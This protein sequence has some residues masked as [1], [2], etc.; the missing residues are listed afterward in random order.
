MKKI[1]VIF[2]SYLTASSVF[3]TNCPEFYLHG[4]EPALSVHLQHEQPLTQELCHSSFATVYSD[5]MRIAFY[6]AEHLTAASVA[7]AKKLR[8]DNLFHEDP[9]LPDVV[10]A[11]LADYKDSG[12]DSGHLASDADMP[13]T[14]A[15]YES[16]SLANMVPQNPTN[17]SGIWNKIERATRRVA[18]TFDDIYVVTGGV[19]NSST[20][21]LK[22][23]IPVPNALF[24]A[25]YIPRTGDAGVYIS[26]NNASGEYKI[27]SLEQLKERTGIDVFPDLP[28][29]VKQLAAELPEAQ[30]I[31][32]VKPF[33]LFKR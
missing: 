10:S 24:K 22:N 13:T 32:K 3:A 17:N 18:T 27:I 29:K 16:F 7:A 6:S 2:L 20:N 30:R 5:S 9:N 14:R 1:S 28:N 33:G 11:D 19:Y 4:Q 15:Q 12:F 26:D 8:R 31:E 23:R 25:I 21:K